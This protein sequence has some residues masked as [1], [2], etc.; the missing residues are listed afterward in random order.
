MTQI[1]TYMILKRVTIFGFIAII[2]ASCGESSTDTSKIN[3]E[4]T[5]KEDTVVSDRSEKIEKI[6]FNIPSPL[7]TTNILKMAGA[8]YEWSLPSNP[9]VVD[10]YHTIKYQALNMGVYGADLNYASVFD[11]TTETMLYLRCAK[12]LGKQLGVEEVFDEETVDRIDNNLENQ[13]SMQVIISETFWRMDS[14][15]KEGGRESISALI[16]AGGWVEGVYLATQLAN[17]APNNENLKQRIAEQKYSLENLIGLLSSYGSEDIDDI[18][19]DLEDLQ[20][21]F[22]EIEE[23]KTPGENT[24]D[25]DG[26]ML[27][28]DQIELKMSDQTL[29]DITE[30]ILELRNEFT[31]Q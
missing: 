18:I 30:R 21:M 29:K 19:E 5:P 4:E 8:T 17:M 27:I 9:E 25:A 1:N 7:E 3:L 2:L 14:H 11:Q 13:D 22:N 26:V 10:D 24:T 12:S 23:I 15:L 6:F 16:V 20:D 31:R 28:G